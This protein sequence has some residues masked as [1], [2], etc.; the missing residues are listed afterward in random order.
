MPTLQLIPPANGPFTI[1]AFGRKF[2]TT[3]G[4]PIT[5]TDNE[6]QIL[7]ANGWII[8]AEGGHGTTSQRPSNPKAG[9]RYSDTTVG[10]VVLW[11]GK[12]WRKVI[13]GGAV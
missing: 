11:D 6:A 3:A 1:E 7:V 2:T 8:S 13:D 10:Y 4:T 9:T 5:V 12:A